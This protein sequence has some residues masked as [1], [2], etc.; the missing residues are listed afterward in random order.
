M[1]P[2][3]TREPGAVG[4]ALDDRESWCGVIVDGEHVHPAVLRI[5]LHAK[6]RG[7]LFL[8]TDAMPPV[9]STESEFVLNGECISCKDGRCVN[10]QGTLAGSCLDMASAVRNTVAQLGVTLAEAVR[11]AATYPAA[12]LGLEH[13][14]GR[15]ARGCAA[16]LVVLDDSMQVRQTWI[17]GERVFVR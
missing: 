12:F 6:P 9:G 2:L 10:A 13:S 5:A 15:I 7:K 8:V 17:G 1:S 11:M 3:G 14:H 16:D 4:S